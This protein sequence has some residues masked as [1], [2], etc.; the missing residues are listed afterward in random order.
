[1]ER[2]ENFF[3]KEKEETIFAEFKEIKIITISIIIV[4]IIIK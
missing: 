4:I 3:K 1:M 2:D